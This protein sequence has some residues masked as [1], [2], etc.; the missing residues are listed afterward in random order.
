MQIVGLLLIIATTQVH[1]QN[2]PYFYGWFFNETIASGLVQ[3]TSDYLAK[4][5]TDVG[6]VQEFL[7]NVSTAAAIDNPMLYYTK[8][9][10]PNTGDYDKSFHITTFYCGTADCSNYTRQVTQYIDQAFPTHLVGVYFTPRTYG[11]RVNLTGIQREIFDLNESNAVDTI[12]AINRNDEPCDSQLVDGIQFCPQDDKNFHPTD[13]RGGG[14][15]D[16]YVVGM[17]PKKFFFLYLFHSSRNLRMCTEYISS[18]N[19]IG[20]DRNFAV[21]NGSW[22]ILCTDSG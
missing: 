18:D 8:P 2:S 5:Y 4:L 9:V 22:S 20:F 19:W 1:C 17:E 13:T 10:D 21:G 3:I 16:V 14:V 12:E 11:I 7:R 6:T 15:L